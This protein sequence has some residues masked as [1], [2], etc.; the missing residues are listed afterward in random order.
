MMRLHLMFLFLILALPGSAQEVKNLNPKIS[1]I[2]GNA[3]YTHTVLQG[4]GLESIA[5]AYHASE[6]EIFLAN[7]DLKG[8]PEVNT[9]LLI[10]YSEASSDKMSA[11]DLKLDSP[12]NTINDFKTPSQEAQ[13]LELE[14]NAKPQIEPDEL[15]ELSDLSA[16]LKEGL[17]QLDS[18]KEG[19]EKKPFL[20][21]DG[22]PK[23]SPVTAFVTKKP[24]RFVV[25]SNKTLSILLDS[26]LHLMLTGQHPDGANAYLKEYFL[27]R[28]NDEGIITNVRDERTETNEN[29]RFIEPNSLK[30]YLLTDSLNKLDR[31]FIPIGFV[32]NIKRDTHL[33]RFKKYGIKM[34]SSSVSSDIE[35]GIF[36]FGSERLL[37][38]RH[39]VYVFQYH[40]YLATYRKFEYNPFGSI[41]QK[42]YL[43]D[44]WKIE[45]AERF[46]RHFLF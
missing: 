1:I 15:D 10:P 45:R 42:L 2:G 38:G 19:I 5:K 30:G 14:R 28:I 16:S 23:H 39:R 3:Y 33:V 22:L 25:D 18:L 41:D 11:F 36:D 34:K 26:I 24:V 43:N 46:R 8:D 29:T 6:K 44:A 7:P 13:S 37:R 31:Q 40:C 27:I 9:Y 20:T 32:I 21:D 12:V 4:Q 35:A 17:N